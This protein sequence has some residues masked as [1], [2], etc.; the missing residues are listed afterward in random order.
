M[1]TLHGSTPSLWRRAEGC[2]P[3]KSTIAFAR[4]SFNPP[5]CPYRINLDL[6]IK[7]PKSY[8]WVH[9]RGFRGQCNHIKDLIPPP[10]S[11]FL[12]IIRDF[13]GPLTRVRVDGRLVRTGDQGDM[14]SQ[15]VM[16]DELALIMASIQEVIASLSIVMRTH[17]LDESQMIML[18]TMPLSGA[19]QRWFASLDVFH[20][21]TYDDFAQEFLR[22]FAFNTVVDISRSELEALRQMSNDLQPRFTRHLIGSTHEGISRGLWLKSSHTDPNGKNPLR[23][24][25][26]DPCYAAQAM[27]RPPSPRH[28]TDRCTTLRHTIHDLID[29]GSVNLGQPSVM[30][31]PL[32]THSTHAV[33]L[34]TGD[35]HFIDLDGD[36][37]IHMMSWED[38][39]LEPIVLDV[40]LEIDGV[41]L[42]HRV[43]FILLDNGFALNVDL[44]F[45]EPEPY[46]LPFIKSLTFDEVQ[47]VTVEESHKDHALLPFDHHSGTIVLNDKVRVYV[48]FKDLNKAKPKDDFL[49]PHIDMLV[50]STIGHS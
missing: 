16:V 8:M 28:N 35:V 46:H 6:F 48:D 47:I 24:Q 7:N 9:L 27:D 4:D 29:R 17:G 19:T 22:Q 32:L 14:N 3:P 20:N 36:D 44:G 26:S 30:A 43:P 11:F 34:P 5:P 37:F 21:R 42:G 13:L 45:I 10:L 25:Y 2:V 23:G 12:G 18:F 33:P 40:R 38:H 41:T 50:G 39:T 15:L 1:I 49:L 31:N